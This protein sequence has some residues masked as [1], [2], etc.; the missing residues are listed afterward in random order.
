MR[1]QVS[2]NRPAAALVGA[3]GF[4]TPPP[5]HRLRSLEH[6]P[7]CAGDGTAPKSVRDP[8]VPE[9]S[10]NGPAKTSP[11]P[12]RRLGTYRLSFAQKMRRVPSPSPRRDH[13]EKGF[14]GTQGRYPSIEIFCCRGS[15]KQNFPSPRDLL[16]K[17]KSCKIFKSCHDFVGNY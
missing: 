16:Y 10:T 6:G 1:R 15:L 12:A 9:A 7:L 14:R 4:V 11:S 8:L 13:V 5:P 2:T 17:K 3:Q